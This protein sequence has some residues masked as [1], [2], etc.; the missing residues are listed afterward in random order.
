MAGAGTAP[1]VMS[2][3]ARLSLLVALL[4]SALAFAAAPALGALSDEVNA[5]RAIAARVDAGTATCANL[6]NTDFEHLGEYVMDQTLGSRSAHE[7]MNARMEAMMG[8]ENADRM[9]QALGRRY[10][11]C[12][13]ATTGAGYGMM[14]G[15][16]MGGSARGWGAMMGSD[17]S[18][19]HDGNWQHMTRAQWQRAAAGMMRGGLAFS[20]GGG[21]GT[22]A[23]LAAVLGGL[24][25]GGLA[26]FAILR[27]TGRQ[28]P[29]SPTTA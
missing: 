8:S 14:A 21:W 7:A 10:A 27:W 24:L 15:G 5:G 17:L 9:H 1:S 18:W 20:G 6:S 16:M 28:R 25:L 23:V 11:G 4:A 19:M 3:T 12:A 29:S 2:V 22:G 26:V 13:T